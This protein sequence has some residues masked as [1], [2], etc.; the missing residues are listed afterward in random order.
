VDSAAPDAL[1]YAAAACACL[2]IASGWTESMWIRNCKTAANPG[3][4]LKPTSGNAKMLL[5]TRLGLLPPTR[6]KSVQIAVLQTKQ[7]GWQNE[8]LKVRPP[9][10]SRVQ[11]SAGRSASAEP[12]IL[13]VHT[14]LNA[15][16]GYSCMLEN[17]YVKTLKGSYYGRPW[18]HFYRKLDTSYHF[19]K[20]VGC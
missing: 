5:T 8:N 9:Q 11:Q 14:L 1:I 16:P 15:L 17:H 3:T 19:C 13:S 6:K 18:R 4:C 20:R 7:S 2:C 10:S 12:K